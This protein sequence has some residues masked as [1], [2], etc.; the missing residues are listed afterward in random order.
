MID[1]KKELAKP[2]V[3][4]GEGWL[5]EMSTAQIKDLMVLRREALG[6]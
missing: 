5:T 2:V 4:A 6:D 1:R 3:G